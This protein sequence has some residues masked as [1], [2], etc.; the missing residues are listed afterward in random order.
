MSQLTAILKYQEVDKKLYAVERELASS[1]ERKEFVKARKFM[2][3]A[4]ERLDA[5]DTKAVSLKARAADL[6]Q[7]YAQAEETL[8]DFDSAQ[9]EQGHIDENGQCTHGANAQNLHD[10]LGKT[11]DTTGVHIMGH[12]EQGKAQGKNGT[13]QNGPEYPTGFLPYILHT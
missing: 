9:N 10:H 1:E 2:E 12:Q 7:K 6:M 11:G 8:A 13:S 3:S 5:L 4:P